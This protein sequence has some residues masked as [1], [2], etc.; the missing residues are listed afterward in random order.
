LRHYGS[1]KLYLIDNILTLVELNNAGLTVGQSVTI[2][3]RAGSVLPRATAVT[4]KLALAF[5]N[6]MIERKPGTSH[7][8]SYSAIS[9]RHMKTEKGQGLDVL[10]QIQYDKQGCVTHIALDSTYD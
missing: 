4:A 1:N 8:L 3:F 5:G 10:Y 6:F 2:S 9:Y 7:S